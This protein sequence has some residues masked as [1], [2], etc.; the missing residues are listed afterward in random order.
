ML[1]LLQLFLISVS[2]YWQD[3]GANFLLAVSKSVVHLQPPTVVTEEASVA[4]SDLVK[5]IILVVFQK[6]C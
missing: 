5:V 1:A 3:L 2:N 4:V 6:V